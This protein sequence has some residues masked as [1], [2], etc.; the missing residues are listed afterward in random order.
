M[1]GHEYGY[2]NKNR[3]YLQQEE[4]PLKSQL[5]EHRP[6]DYAHSPGHFPRAARVHE[7]TQGS[8]LT[9]ILPG[10]TSPCSC[11]TPSVVAF[12]ITMGGKRCVGRVFSINQ[13]F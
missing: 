11:V 9:E 4:I 7:A 10:C 2:V 5:L 12:G 8:R 13:G 1:I 3:L 6:V